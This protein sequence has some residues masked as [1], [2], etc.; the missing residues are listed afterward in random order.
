M[1]M[2]EVMAAAGWEPLDEVGRR[3]GQ[4]GP[5]TGSS[6]RSKV[7]GSVCQ[8]VHVCVCVCFSLSGAFRLSHSHSVWQVS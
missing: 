5:D 1:G 4:F 7:T 2:P 3:S 8:D 6:W